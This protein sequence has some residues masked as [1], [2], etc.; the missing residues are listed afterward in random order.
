M[1]KALR[2]RS[3]LFFTPSALVKISQ[4]NQKNRLFQL[5]TFST[6]GNWARIIRRATNVSLNVRS[7]SALQISVRYEK[8]WGN[9]MK[10]VVNLIEEF[11][12]L[13]L[14]WFMRIKMR[15]WKM[16]TQNKRKWNHAPRERVWSASV[17]SSSVCSSRR[18]FLPLDA[19]SWILSMMCCV[20]RFILYRV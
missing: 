16:R 11:V 17:F 8:N 5:L 6:C 7:S 1:H 2:R 15:K 12:A 14:K 4:Y 19:A 20:V 9:K 13:R 10:I 3:H 18:R